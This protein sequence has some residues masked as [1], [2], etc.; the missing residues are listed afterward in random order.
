MQIDLSKISFTKAQVHKRYDQSFITRYAIVAEVVKEIKRS[1]DSE[2][3][4]KILDLGGYN[5]LARQLLDDQVT[6][7]DVY[8]DD[9][10]EDYIQVDKVGIPCDDDEFDIV[11]STDVVEHIPGDKRDRFLHDAIRVAKY[12]T[13]I[14]APFE[15]NKGEVAFEEM[16]ANTLYRGA[17]GGDDYHWLQEHRDNVLPK[18][19]WIENELKKDKT[20]SY[21]RFSHSSLRLW[22]E[23]LSTG[24]FVANNVAEVDKI[25]GDKLKSLNDTYFDL[26]A[27]IDF[28][29]NGYRSFY[30]ISK[31]FNKINVT[32][33]SY[34]PGAV[35]QFTSE[36]RE[37]LGGS[38]AK[39][40]EMVYQ[41]R[42]DVKRHVAQDK[43]ISSE[44]D[45][46]HHI[47]TRYN[48]LGLGRLYSAYRKTKLV[49]G[50]NKKDN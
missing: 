20:V 42:L 23:L 30:V 10:L 41:Y 43:K 22:S 13:I 1:I 49:V 18:R 34:D 33:P 19:S 40:S 46:L 38:I 9:T 25:L 32:V 39:L 31:H 27:P 29:E 16:I 5:G 24:F 50:G 3:K 2:R 26:I 36:V 14:A 15:H 35:E 17:V 6:I 45:R 28:P 7:L 47:E 21:S 8:Q 37:T 12:A 4:L 44:L 48:K 11:I